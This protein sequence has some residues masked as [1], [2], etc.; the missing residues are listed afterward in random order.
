MNT[1]TPGGGRQDQGVPLISWRTRA[2]MTLGGLALGAAL[3]WHVAVWATADG[4]SLADVG[5]TWAALL[6]GHPLTG[7]PGVRAAS[8]ATT[9]IACGLILALMIAALLGA[10]FALGSWQGSRRRGKGLARAGEV[11]KGVGLERARQKAGHT[12]PSMSAA[13]IRAAAPQ[14]VALHVGDEVGS[15]EP[16]YLS[17]EDHLMVL[18]L[19]GAG[20]SRDVLIPAALSAPGPLLVTTTK[21]DLVDAIASTRSR[22]GRIWVFDPLG[23]SS[24]PESM[25]WDPVAGC[26]QADVAESRGSAFSAG[27]AADDTAST[28]SSFFQGQTTSAIKRMMHAAALDGRGVDDVM[29]W[30]MALAT[31]AEVPRAIIEESTS[32]FAEHRW[33]AMLAA[34]ATGA[35]ETVASTRATLERAIDPLATT[36]IMAWLVPR[37]GVD[38]FDPAAFVAST[39][40]LVLVADANSATNVGPLT[41]ML[42][43]EIIDVAKRVA[44]TRPGGVL[45][46]PLRVVGDE[47]AN[48]APLPKMPEVATDARGY[49]IQLI[50]AL[51][52]AAQAERRWGKDGAKNLLTQMSAE[53]VLPGL[54]EEETLSRYSDLVGIVEVT[55]SSTSF[56][57]DG[58]LASESTSTRER[59]IM[60]ADEIRRIP[61]G[62][63]LMIFRNVDPIMVQFT[64][65]YEGKNGSTLRADAAASQA[66]RTAHQVLVDQDL[67]ALVQAHRAS[68][69][70]PA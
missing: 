64:P 31:G 49:G 14:D 50:L 46:P 36:K 62:Q 12:R 42:F 60:R 55:E 69:A 53:V 29:D 34:T 26:E 3:S 25:V 43:Q 40:T 57:L 15:G 17:L 68:V 21:V 19:S 28:N 32:P 6:R 4:L 24:W 23:L 9:L 54:K 13:Q 59:R 5:T 48:V 41:T 45:D 10:V 61:D 11:R 16:V 66:R 51:Q 58:R 44:R 30:A 67:S 56:D 22:K 2:N 20:K 63:G 1:P 65:W 52:S 35:P 7:M 27:L 37:P 33:A 38:V 47:I 18:A 8:T 70:R 39:D